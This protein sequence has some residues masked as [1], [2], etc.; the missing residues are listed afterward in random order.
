VKKIALMLPC[1]F[2]WCFMGTAC[3]E[4]GQHFERYLTAYRCRQLS[5]ADLIRVCGAVGYVAA[6][7]IV[8]DAKVD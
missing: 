7:V 3:T 4:E 1:I 8:K 2:C 6:G 5:R